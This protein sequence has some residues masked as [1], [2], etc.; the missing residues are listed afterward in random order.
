MHNFAVVMIIFFLLN[1]MLYGAY[2]AT[3][4]N[5]KSLLQ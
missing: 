5:H 3:F 2:Y 1:D 4:L